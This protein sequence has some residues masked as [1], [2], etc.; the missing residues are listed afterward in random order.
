[1]ADGV[2]IDRSELYAGEEVFFCG[3]GWGNHP[4]TSIDGL[5]I[6]AGRASGSAAAEDVFEGRVPD[7]SKW[8]VPVYQ[9]SRV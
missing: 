5:P 7:H 8:R 9:S 6:G 1:V 4:I 2:K 3:T